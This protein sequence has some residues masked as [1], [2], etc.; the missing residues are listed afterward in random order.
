MPRIRG[1]EKEEPVQT[2]NQEGARERGR[3]SRLRF[4]LVAVGAAVG[5]ILASI[6]LAEAQSDPATGRTAL[7]EHR[8]RSGHSPGR[9]HHG[10]VAGIHG[11]FTARAPGGGYQTLATQAGDVTDT[12]RSSI[13]VRSEDGYSRTYTVDD[14][15]M[16]NAGNDGIAD[17]R[18]GDL[19]RVTAVVTDGNARAVDVRDVT[20]SRALRDRWVPPR[21]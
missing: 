11:E 3:S 16:V 1:R 20:Q 19:V 6:G 18:Q 8:D 15:T 2:R 13:T 12:N 10:P 14:S 9:G 4:G 17:V 7:A 5:V 21:D